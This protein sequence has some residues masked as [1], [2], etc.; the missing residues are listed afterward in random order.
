MTAKQRGIS[1]Q[2]LEDIFAE[3]YAKFPVATFW[4]IRFG[5]YTRVAIGKACHRCETTPACANGCVLS[6]G[7]VR[8]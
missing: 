3:V 2:D 1:G 5:R 4:R 8:K 7:K 6:E